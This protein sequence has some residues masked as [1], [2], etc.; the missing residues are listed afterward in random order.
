MTKRENIYGKAD[1]KYVKTVILYANS[2]DELFYDAAAKD[3]KVLAVDL[4]DLFLKGVTVKKENAYYKGICL[5][6]NNIIGHDGTAAKTFG[7][8]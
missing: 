3:N 8:A 5:K 7:L 6:T 2:T 1:E 4:E